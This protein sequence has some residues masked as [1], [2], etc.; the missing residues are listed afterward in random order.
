[1]KPTTKA[2]IHP[3]ILIS[4]FFNG[5][6]II[7]RPNE[8]SGKGWPMAYALPFHPTLHPKLYFSGCRL[9]PRAPGKEMLDMAQAAFALLLMA[10]SMMD[11]KT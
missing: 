10:L 8:L 6:W 2:K 3:G 9:F 4:T 1:M 5:D 11:T 7:G